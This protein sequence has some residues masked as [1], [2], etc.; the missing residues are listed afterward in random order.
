MAILPKFLKDWIQETLNR[1][2]IKK[3]KYFTYWQ[4]A[5]GVTTAICGIPYILVQFN[6]TLPEPFASLSNKVVTWAAGAAF[7]M[8][9]LTVSTPTV[10]QTEAGSAVKVTDKEKM[11][12]TTKV[13]DKKVDDA[14]PPP[15][16]ADV[17][18]ASESNSS[19]TGSGTE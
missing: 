16:V 8:A 14:V 19:I 3:P 13:E 1:W 5:T 15:P 7:M 11:P 18:E 4:W 9:Q 17:P 6:V 10:A 12:F 2:F